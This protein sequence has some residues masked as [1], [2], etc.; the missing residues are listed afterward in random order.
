MAPLSSRTSHLTSSS[1]IVSERNTER[2]LQ[3]SDSLEA[4]FSLMLCSLSDV[5]IFMTEPMEEVEVSM[6]LTMFAIVSSAML[7]GAFGAGGAAANQGSRSILRV[8]RSGESS[9]YSL[10][11]SV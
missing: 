7:P 5:D 2:S 3:L 1:D 4:H 6:E 9:F 11:A 10:G 8:H